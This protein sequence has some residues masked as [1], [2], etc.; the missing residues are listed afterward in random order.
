[1]KIF[2]V[3]I[4]KFRSIDKGEF[5]LSQLNAIVGQNNSGK[6]GVMR[7]LNSFFNPK[8]EIEYYKDGTN[9]Y[10]STNTV[11][12]ITI[13]FTNVQQ[14]S[15][16]SKYV[17][18]GYLSIKHEYNKK[19]KRLD[20]S[21]FDTNKKYRAL[22]EDELDQLHQGIQFVLI[23]S[24]RGS[25]HN[26][27]NETGVLRQLFDTF[28]TSHTAKR[29]TLTPK[30]KSA[31]NYFKDNALNKVAQGIEG[32]YLAK[33]GFKINIDSQFPLSY[34]LFVN[35]LII[36]ISEG[37]R[38]FSLEEC[39]SGIQSLVA[40]SV[41][42]YLAELNHSNFIIGIEEPEV[43]LHPQAQK[44]LIH[45]LLDEINENDV[46]I[47]FT[48]HSTVI[49]DQL[50]HSDIILVRKVTDPKR[51]FK[52][53]IKQLS[54]T[55]WNDYSLDELKYNKFHRFRNSEFFFANHILVTESDTD[56]EVFRELLDRNKINIEKSGIS[57]LELGGITSLKYAFYL[58]RDLEL[59]KT[60]VIDK[61]F[62]F[63]Y[64]N[65]KKVD[66][67]DGRGFFKYGKT[68]KS[69]QLINEL[70]DNESKRS[71]IEDY[72]ANNHTKSLQLTP[73]FDVIC[74]KY[75]L[76]MDLLATSNSQNVVY[77]YLNVQPEQRNTAY[78]F[79][80]K[81]DA[82]K[83]VSLLLHVIQNSTRQNLPYSYRYIIKRFEKYA[84]K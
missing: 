50:D 39:G 68:F 55:F 13:V 25:M 20:Y 75:N 30:V 62:F 1:M 54:S 23:P 31:F 21:V 17:Q 2:K 81:E 42:K 15:I 9:L 22:T 66:S 4:S 63:P 40:I 24:E 51:K 64:S 59:E 47:I 28:F 43:N 7:A 60:F 65:N 26:L 44:E 36:K 77:N 45:S 82:L 5:H 37:D 27:R 56:S 53:K 52:T 83:E 74:M 84:N 49:I 69:N 33:R 19:R 79:L 32:K 41:Y 3:E 38:D 57:V 61:D 8:N 18:N 78:L 12:R 67:R 46:Q 35:D 70:F 29:D 73:D 80:N 71:I 34:D 10:S 6:S 58:I 48:T 14:D 11:P 72:L 76:E 16:L